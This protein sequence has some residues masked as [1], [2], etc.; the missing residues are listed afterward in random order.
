MNNNTATIIVLA[1]FALIII[2]VILAFRQQIEIK[3]KG[4]LGMEIDVKAAN[5]TSA[6]AGDALIEDVEAGGDATASASTGGDAV[7]RR[8]KAEGNVTAIS[9]PPGDSP[10][11]KA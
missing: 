11:P 2:A 9:T 8:T 4:F 3:I 5:A 7:V 10:D 6:K 1:L